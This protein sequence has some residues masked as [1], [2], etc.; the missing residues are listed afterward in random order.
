ME[1]IERTWWARPGL[2]VRDG[3]LLVA[4]RDAE[5]LA[6]THGTPVFVHDHTTVVAQA[7]RLRDAMERADLTWRIRFALKAQ[8]DPAFL[9]ALRARA[10]FVGMDVCSP[11]E[12]AWALGHGWRPDEISYT[13]TNVS[14]RDL[15]AILDAGVHVNVDLLSQLERYGRAAPGTAV[16]IRV[17]PGVGADHTGATETKYAGSRPTKFGILP[18]RLDDAIAIARRH[19]LTIDTVHYHSGYLYMTAS[20]PVIEE[21]G[22]RV[23]SVVRRLRDAGYPVT[24]VNTGGG[25]GVRF[26]PGDAGLD[27]G[28]WADALARAY[29]GID[30]LIV[31]TEPGEYLAKFGATLL[32]EVVTVEDRGQGATFVGLDA[33]W[34]S[35]NE[36]FVYRIPFHPILCRAADAAPAG[37]VTVSGHINEGDDLFAEDVPMPEVR[38]GDIV[39]IPNVGAYNL[40]MV[41]E[42]CLRPPVPVVAFDDRA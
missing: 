32:A 40:S 38:E 25:L 34:S 6:R 11:G 18:E 7:E 30:D 23:A 31:A 37:S 33:G 24:E 17:N 19:D 8:R 28:A 12:V 29:G 1:T 35:L 13:G 5:E 14:D 10:S 26:R 20:I 27:V 9:A 15:A 21:A 39:A 42:H 22:R 3:R 36:H 41:S 2:E 16:G 4:G